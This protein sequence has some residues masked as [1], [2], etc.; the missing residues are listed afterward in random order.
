M[1][2]N[3]HASLI[4]KYEAESPVSTWLPKQRFT[5]PRFPVTKDSHGKLKRATSKVG[6]SHSSFPSFCKL[7]YRCDGKNWRN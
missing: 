7:E 2:P 6:L 3:I 5:F 1:F 4:T